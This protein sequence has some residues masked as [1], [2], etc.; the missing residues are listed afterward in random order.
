MSNIIY[1]DN[2]GS[3]RVRQE[4]IDEML[5]ILSESYPNPSS[6]YSL[7]RGAKARIEEAREK[8]A[9]AIGAQPREIFFTS[10]GTEA[11]NWAIQG[12]ARARAAKGK[13]IIT[14][15]I[16]H[17]GILSTCRYMESV[18]Y[19]ITY[20]PVDSEGLVNPK[21]LEAAIR[22]DTVLVTIMYVN[23]EVGTI[24]PITELGRISREHGVA[25]HTDAVQAVGH[26]HIDVEAQNIDLLSLSGHK[27]YAPKGVGALYVRKGIDISN[28]IYGGGQERGMRASTENA[29]G[30]VALGKAAELA[31]QDFEKET[32]EVARLRDKLIDGI[33][34][35]IKYTQLNG[36]RNQRVPGIANISFEYIEGESLLMLLDHKGICVSSGSA[37]ASGSLN[38]SHVL[39][40]MGLPHEKAHGSLRLSLGRYNTDANVDTVIAT[41]VPMVQRL[42][43][44]SPTYPKS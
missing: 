37:C 36:C 7:A 13:H 14:S 25:F 38:P 39:L 22:P 18:G 12:I 23:N 31:M 3:T 43:E 16:E 29:A 21:D 42:R 8:V 2:A 24:Q 34:S 20:L 19:E 11:D 40:A 32:A 1:M 5:P 44:M 41:L 30:I 35:K 9:A 27:L 4:V 15:A 26:V 28:F 33:L 6:V 17:P 10:G